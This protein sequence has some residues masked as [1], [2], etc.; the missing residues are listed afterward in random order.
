MAARPDGEGRT[1]EGEE[2]EEDE[3]EE[4]DDDEEEEREEGAAAAVAECKERNPPTTLSSQCQARQ[5]LR[6]M[7]HGTSAC[8]TACE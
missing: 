6:K 7:K 5:G 8:V 1:L 3:E 4:E 2:D